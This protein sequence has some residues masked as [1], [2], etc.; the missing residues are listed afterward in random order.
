MSKDKVSRISRAARQ[1]AGICLAIAA[2]FCASLQSGS[3]QESMDEQTK[4]DEQ[5][6][7][8]TLSKSPAS[9]LDVGLI[10]LRQTEIVTFLANKPQIFKRGAFGYLDVSYDSTAQEIL[11]EVSYRSEAAEAGAIVDDCKDS[12][13]LAISALVRSVPSGVASIVGSGDKRARECKANSFFLS[14]SIPRVQQLQITSPAWSICDSIRVVVKTL[15]DKNMIACRKGLTDKD[16]V[17]I[18]N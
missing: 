12:L 1:R 11:V 16:I 9:A 8:D 10:G 3:A 15:N 6:I 2:T 7:L 18:R 14:D 5:E 17:V 13:E 4:K